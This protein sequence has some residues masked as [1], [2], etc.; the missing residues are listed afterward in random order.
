[1]IF[2]L[3]HSGFSLWRS[4]L[5]SYFLLEVLM[6]KF[7]QRG[8]YSYL[9]VTD[10]PFFKN[11]FRV[12]EIKVIRFSNIYWNQECIELTIVKLGH[13]KTEREYTNWSD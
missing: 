12:K 1:M 8:S 6:K 9:P 2:N 5:I 4:F 11:K 7:I 10:K 13:M 3:T